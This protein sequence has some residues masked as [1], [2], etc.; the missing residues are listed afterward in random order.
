MASSTVT[1]AVKNRFNGTSIPATQ[2]GPN[3]LFISKGPNWRSGIQAELQM[4][5]GLGQKD[6]R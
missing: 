4:G 6:G 5:N 2:Q 1:V 3:I